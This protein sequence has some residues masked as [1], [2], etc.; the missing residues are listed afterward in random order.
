ME[1]EHVIEAAIDGIRNPYEIRY[2]Q[3]NTQFYLVAVDAPAEVRFERMRERRRSGDPENLEEFVRV[4]ARDRGAGEAE[5]GQQVG[6]C[7]SAA[8]FSIWNDG[9]LTELRSKV[10]AVLSKIPRDTG[11]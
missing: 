4:D 3:E 6:A 7:I 5:K 1:R 2:L 9:A 10:A 8:D 11:K